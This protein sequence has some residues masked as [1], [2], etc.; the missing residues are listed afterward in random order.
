[1]EKNWK[2]YLKRIVLLLCVVVFVV[3]SILLF[4]EV[5]SRD[6]SENDYKELRKDVKKKPKSEKKN[7]ID[8]DALK[9]QNSDIYAWLKINNTSI[10]YPI[11]MSNEEED[12]DYYL[13]HNIDHSSGRPGCLYV[14]KEQS[15]VFTE[16]F[17]TIIY[18]HNM[19]N[20]GTM[21]YDLTKFQDEAFFN[22]N[23]TFTIE[24]ESKIYTYKIY[25]AVSHD[26]NHLL[27]FYDFKTPSG[28]TKYID[29][30]KNTSDQYS[31]VRSDMEVDVN[32]DKLVTFSTCMTRDSSHRYLVVGVLQNEQ[33]KEK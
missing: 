14:E 28:R 5:I 10:D 19:Y 7:Y 25:C 31:H 8:F 11:L 33:N 29:D 21:F 13:L 24:T 12:T 16:N 20:N 22:D 3:S 32:K 17:N 27:Y 23:A 1:M 2:Y 15:K 9:A 30:L 4:R 26:D 18:G 6:K